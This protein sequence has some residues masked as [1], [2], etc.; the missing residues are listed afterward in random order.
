MSD[1]CFGGSSG[2]L[3][4]DLGD[5]AGGSQI[6]SDRRGACVLHPRHNQS[7]TKETETVEP[8]EKKAEK[9]EKAEKT[10]KVEK[11]EKAEKDRAHPSVSGGGNANAL[12][13]LVD[14][15]LPQF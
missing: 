14:F 4:A 2:C 8:Q 5:K 6:F 15:I 10:E 3:W 1:A 7:G 11:A 13:V 12:T 9:V